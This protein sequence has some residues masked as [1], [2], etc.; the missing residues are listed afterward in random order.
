V[1]ALLHQGGG[2]QA[3]PAGLLRLA[4]QLEQQGPFVARLR[5]LGKSLDHGVA[6]LQQGGQT[7]QID[8]T[9]A[10]VDPGLAFAR[11]RWSAAAAEGDP[12]QTRPQGWR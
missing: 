5:M 10:V 2:L 7:I 4:G 3:V 6:V 9:Q 8:A 1:L 11:F 12:K